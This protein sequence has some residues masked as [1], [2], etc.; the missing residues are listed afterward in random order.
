MRLLCEVGADKD[1]AT[2]AGTTPLWVAAQ[3]GHLE[4][5][6]ALCEARACAAAAQLCGGALAFNA[7]CRVQMNK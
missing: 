1:K 4:A 3:N 6:C 7:Q 5:A 2:L